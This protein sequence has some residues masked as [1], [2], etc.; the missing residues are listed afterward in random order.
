MGRIE[1]LETNMPEEAGTEKA[2][3]IPEEPSQTEA[4]T[5]TSA[6]STE[7]ER[8]I[9]T[10]STE[11]NVVNGK[12]PSLADY[13]A[14]EA[15]L[16]V[17]EQHLAAPAATT[18]TPEDDFSFDEDDFDY[19]TPKKTTTTPA[20]TTAATTIS[21]SLTSA[22][23]QI[24]TTPVTTTT[25]AWTTTV[26]NTTTTTEATTTA[27][28]TTA[29]ET[30]TAETTTEATTTTTEATTTTEETTTTT[31]PPETEET[32][33]GTD[34]LSW[35]DQVTA[36]STT[37]A[38]TTTEE[39]TT[40]APAVPE[41]S[42]TDIL[43]TVNAG[44]TVVT[45]Y[46]SVVVA[47]AVMAEVGDSFD[48]DAIKAQAIATY[49]YIRYYNEN[50]Q[51]AYVI[52]KTPSD[53]VT[54]CVNEVLGKELRY[55][56]KLI[57]SVY[58]ASTA[59]YTASSVNVWGV[60]YPYLR[61]VKTEFD[62]LYDINYGRTATFTSEEIKDLVESNTGITL[63][64]DPSTWFEITSHIDGNYVGSLSICG[65]ETYHNG[66]RNVTI[67][68]R[69]FRELI[70][71]YGI[72]S[73]SFDISY[74]AETDTFTFTTYGYGHGVGMSQHGANILATQYGYSYEEILGFYYQGAVIS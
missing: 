13:T 54:R 38:E 25:E 60:D 21:T 9:Y 68:G 40:E 6:P 5:T 70:L 44:G 8:V 42:V 26:E 46:A 3:D 36:E 37:T 23:T 52:F 11:L 50:G 7:T 67:T 34:P 51:N 33:S 57:Q 35:M 74:D 12:K 45:D 58:C 30:T 61:S 64:G 69:V 19:T 28:T 17:E 48:E 31:T 18:T 49:T 43:V 72:R 55:D 59:G 71:E 1:S 63:T 73:A 22:S 20:T 4:S 14:T 27:T 53:K 32:T 56:G 47:K 39:T 66:T 65:Q 2:E 24:I 29:A 62:A 41:T 15:M 10:Y 16:I